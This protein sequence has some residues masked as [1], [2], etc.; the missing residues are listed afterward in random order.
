MQDQ[1]ARN[2]MGTAEETA[3]RIDAE[4][5]LIVE[6]ATDRALWFARELIEIHPNLELV[7]VPAGVRALGLT[8]G[9]YH[10]KFRNDRGPDA[11]L[12]ALRRQGRVRR[13]ALRNP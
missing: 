3:K 9:R 8:P 2:L 1:T 4:R 6:D 13:A 11:L 10:I 5:D 12:P 7:F